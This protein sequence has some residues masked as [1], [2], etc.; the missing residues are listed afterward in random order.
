MSPTRILSYSTVFEIE[1]KTFIMISPIAEENLPLTNKYR[2]THLTVHPNIKNYEFSIAEKA[3]F[4]DHICTKDV[5][6]LKSCYYNST[7][8]DFE[9]TV[10]IENDTKL[11]YENNFIP[12]IM[13]GSFYGR[14]LLSN[15]KIK[16]D[17]LMDK[18]DLWVN[19]ILE[20]ATV[21]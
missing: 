4:M 19:W 18:S 3:I 13:D 17:V 21:N 16:C 12:S 9:M 10:H 15:I 7:T 8:R 20:E 6:Y 14:L 5:E 2:R 1:G 11:R